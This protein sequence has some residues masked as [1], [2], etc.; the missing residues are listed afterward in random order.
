MEAAER[1]GSTTLI[2]NPAIGN[3][4]DPHPSTSQSHNRSFYDPY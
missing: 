1:E 2:R 4:P 3:D